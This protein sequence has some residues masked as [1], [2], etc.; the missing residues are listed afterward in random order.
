MDMEVNEGTIDDSPVD[1]QV[2]GINDF[3]NSIRLL[4]FSGCHPCRRSRGV[5]ILLSDDCMKGLLYVE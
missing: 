4:S 2:V 5:S 1:R 3:L